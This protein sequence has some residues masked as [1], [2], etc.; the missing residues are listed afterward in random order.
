MFKYL[1][2]IDLFRA[3]IH[4]NHRID[5]LLLSIKS[6]SIILDTSQ[7]NPNAVR[8]VDMQQLIQSEH[9]WAKRLRLSI[10]TLRLCD[11]IAPC[12]LFF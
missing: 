3:W 6:C 7:I 5:E 12:R 2:S 9:S 4:L 1:S 10:D 11:T 8:F